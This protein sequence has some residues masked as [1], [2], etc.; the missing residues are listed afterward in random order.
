MKQV[1][2]T[3]MDSKA[4]ENSVAK[5]VSKIFSAKNVN[6]VQE[7]F[8]SSSSSFAVFSRRVLIDLKNFRKK[9]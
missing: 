8:T 7:I 4:S 3:D 5:W 9:Q 1:G 6:K 2:F